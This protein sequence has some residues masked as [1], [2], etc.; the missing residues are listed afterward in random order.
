MKLISPSFKSENETTQQAVERRK[1]SYINDKWNQIK[2]P[3]NFLAHTNKNNCVTK[4]D[5][6]WDD[7]KEWVK[8]RQ[9]ARAQ[10]PGSIY[11][12]DQVFEMYQFMKK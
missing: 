8:G 4:Y 12:K 6:N 9:S 3:V 2:I 1:Q 5:V 7:E 10:R 11:W